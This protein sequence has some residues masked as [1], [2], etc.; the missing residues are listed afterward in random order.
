[1]DWTGRWAGGRTATDRHGRTVWLIERQVDRVR[2]RLRLRVESEGAALAELALFDRDPA[3]Y[4]AKDDEDRGRVLLDADA[5]AGLLRHLAAEGR[6][7]AYRKNVRLYAAQ[8]IAALDGR[9]LRKVTLADLQRLLDEWKTARRH[10][11]IAIKTLTA[12][13]RERTAVLLTGDD[14][15]AALRVP[16]ARPEKASRAKGWSVEAVEAVYR[17]VGPQDVRDVMALRARTGLHETEVSR[18]AE[19]RAVLSRVDAGEIVG[20]VRLDHKSGRIHTQ[21]LDAQAFAAALRIATLRRPLDNA[22][23]NREV[24]VAFGRVNAMRREALPLHG[25]GEL[26]HSFVTWA[27]TLG[28]EVRAAGTGV[29]LALVAETIGHATTRTTSRFYDGTEVPVMIALPLRLVHPSDP[30]IPAARPAASRGWS[31]GAGA[32]E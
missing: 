18:I 30:P 22:R 2:H 24:R 23:L 29:P 25:L 7:I 5:L 32:D 4:L 31:Q 21:S 3:A 26:R 17:Q 12:Y 8:W 13:L 9:D 19:G 6:T 11:I 1:M 14:P 10:R 20:T 15:T 16:Q 28:R 27:K